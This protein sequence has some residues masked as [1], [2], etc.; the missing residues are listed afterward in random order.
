MPQFKNSLYRFLNDGLSF[1]SHEASQIKSLY[2]P[3]CG[4]E[5]QH[6]KSS[7]TPSLS[8]DIKL[9]RDH[10]LTKPV[11]REELRHPLRNF[12]IWVK[13]KGVVSIAEESLKGSSYIEAGPL[14]HELT[15]TYPEI[16]LS[17][18]VINFI[19]VSG[20]NVELMRIRIKNISRKK[21][22]FIPTASIPIF[23]RSLDNKHD[24]EHVT[25]LLHRIV[26]V[27]YGVIVEPAMVFNER[28]HKPNETAYFVYG[29]EGKGS[30]PTGSFPTVSSFYG[31]RGT[32]DARFRGRF[33]APGRSRFRH[34]SESSAAFGGAVS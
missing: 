28:G 21:C 8:G 1:S 32:A 17:I 3:L 13:D 6:L 24:H 27:D 16:G 4:V 15:R 5:A 31:D 22:V 11:S 33:G 10:F 20:Q 9:H 19:P 34:L 29:F 26:Q 14:W 23:G 30:K 2:F 7:I 18:E 12:F 25:S